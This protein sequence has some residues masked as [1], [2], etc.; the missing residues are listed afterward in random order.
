MKW[1]IVEGQV[2]GGISSFSLGVSSYG[3]DPLMWIYFLIGWYWAFL[4]HQVLW[5]F[6]IYGSSK[7][8]LYVGGSYSNEE[9]ENQKRKIVEQ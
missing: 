2:C 9:G 5:V 6:R 8:G 4:K 7:H 3:Q 1:R